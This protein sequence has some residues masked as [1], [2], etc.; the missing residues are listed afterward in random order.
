MSIELVIGA[1]VV[2]GIVA[3]FVMKDAKEDTPVEPTLKA[4]K[5]EAETPV[6]PAK[7]AAPKKK[8][9]AKKK[10]APKKA[11]PKKAAPSKRGRPAKKKD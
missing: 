5:A 6:A 10:T 8:A 3:Y 9:P 1:V 11:A 2:I 4:D 7:K